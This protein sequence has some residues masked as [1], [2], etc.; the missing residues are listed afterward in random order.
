VWHE[1]KKLMEYP[2]TIQVDQ[3]TQ[4]EI[5]VNSSTFA[6]ATPVGQVKT[7]VLSAIGN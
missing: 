5:K 2:V 1:G 7:V 6:Q 3:T 4:A